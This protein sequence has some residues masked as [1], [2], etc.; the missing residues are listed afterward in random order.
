[1]AEFKVLLNRIV[2]NFPSHGA[3]AKALGVT[4]SRLSRA[5]SG[6]GGDFPFNVVNCLRLAKLSGESPSQIL[7]AAKKGEIADLIEG[8]YGRDRGGLLTQDERTFLARISALDAGDR[9]LLQKLMDRFF[10]VERV[11]TKLKASGRL[12]RVSEAAEKKGR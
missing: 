9:E 5:L 11:V 4:P 10:P 2:R 6:A 8:L 12:A 7:R 3:L 1:V